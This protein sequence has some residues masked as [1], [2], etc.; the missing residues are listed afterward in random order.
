MVGRGTHNLEHVMFAGPLSGIRKRVT[1]SLTAG[2]GKRR[3]RV[4]RQSKNDFLDLGAAA[5]KTGE[6]KEAVM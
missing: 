3:G 5:K 4:Y 1:V 2:R 6:V